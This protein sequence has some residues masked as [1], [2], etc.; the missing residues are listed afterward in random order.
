MIKKI[1]ITNNKARPSLRETT[2]GRMY[3]VSNFKN[4]FDE[5]FLSF[6]DD[7]DDNVYIFEDG[8]GYEVVEE[9]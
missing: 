8:N 7:A 3:R 6:T 1:K 5:P 2:N 4:S 9:D